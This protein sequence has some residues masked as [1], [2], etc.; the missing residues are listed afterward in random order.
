MHSA[1]RALLILLG[2]TQWLV[3]QGTFRNL[4]FESATVPVLLPGQSG[5]FVPFND[6]FPDWV[7][8]LGTDNASLAA[9]NGLS[10]GGVLLSILGP[11]FPVRLD[12]NFT[13]ALQAGGRFSDGA[14]VPAALAQIGTIPSLS[15]SLVFYSSVSRPEVTFN[16]QLLPLVFLGNG[17]SS[18]GNAYEILGADVSAYAGQSGELRF[19]SLPSGGIT[20]LNLTYLDN[21]QFSNQPIP[22]PGVFGL[23]A[24]G[25]FLL[26]W[27]FRRWKKFRP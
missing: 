17:M 16:S 7:G 12:G 4:D 18:G 8:F 23:F 20:P 1:L 27:R 14:P 6:A 3:A 19:T 21:I 26:G 22:E 5:G 15:L 24:L 11:N 13:A 10:A 2:T 25:A 9:H